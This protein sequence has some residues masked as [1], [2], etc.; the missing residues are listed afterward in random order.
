M[1]YAIWKYILRW[2][3]N[4][5]LKIWNLI[6]CTRIN[7]WNLVDNKN[8]LSEHL[9]DNKNTLISPPWKIITKFIAH[10]KEDEYCEFFSHP[11]TMGQNNLSNYVLNSYFMSGKTHLSVLK[12]SL[13]WRQNSSPDNSLK[14]QFL[15][16]F[17][18]LSGTR[19]RNYDY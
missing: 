8:T 10:S 18:I 19:G 14:P 13:V 9:V 17:R 5:A 7:V 15:L 1:C 4:L 6:F 2:R 3:F 11:V 12:Y 16:Y